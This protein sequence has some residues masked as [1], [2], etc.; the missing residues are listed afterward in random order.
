METFLVSIVLYRNRWCSG[1][2]RPSPIDPFEQHRELRPAQRDYP[3][4]RLRP[5][6]A[7]AFEPLVAQARMQVLRSQRRILCGLCTRFIRSAASNSLAWPSDI[8]LT[9]DV[10]CFKSTME[11]SALFPSGGLI[12]LLPTRRLS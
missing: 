9:E 1:S 3:F 12:W 8:T 7:A 4:L 10:S 5:D 11:P 2:Y 6:E